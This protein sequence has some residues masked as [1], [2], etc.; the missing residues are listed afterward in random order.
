MIVKTFNV[1]PRFF[2]TANPTLENY[3]WVIYNNSLSGI[4]K[5]NFKNYLNYFQHPEISFRYF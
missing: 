3:Y 5:Y 1:L 4:K 2:L